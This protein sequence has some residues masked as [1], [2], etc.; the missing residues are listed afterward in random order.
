MQRA[1]GMD[2]KVLNGRLR[3]VLVRAVGDAFVTD[4]F[5]TNA[6]LATLGAGGRLCDGLC[7]E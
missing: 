7:D 2:K 4:S 1:M 3:L 5:D 6:L